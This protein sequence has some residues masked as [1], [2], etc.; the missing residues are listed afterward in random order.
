MARAVRL[1]R[2]AKAMIVSELAMWGVLGRWIVR[3]PDVPH[4]ATPVPYGRMVTPVLWLWVIGSVTEAVAVELI[5]RSIDATWAHVIR[6]PML[7]LGVW[8]ALY[9]A[10]M[11]GAISMRRHLVFP[12][13]IEVRNGARV[14]VVVP[15]GA[16]EECR[17]IEHD[18]N[19][20]VRTL[21]LTDGLLLVG[22]SGRTNVELELREPTA[23]RTHDGERVAQRVGLWVDEPRDFIRMWRE[24][25]V[26][27]A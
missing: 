14:S 1:A 3:R 26:A 12:D 15:A 25:D 8:G 23:L 10:G 17:A 6:T 22:V 20:S 7:I 27:R 16:V 4:G 5:L 11:V 24:R 21:Q 13:R 2:V 19:S 9:M 18:L